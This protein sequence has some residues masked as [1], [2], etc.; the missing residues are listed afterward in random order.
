M[1]KAMKLIIFDLD[2]TILDVLPIHDMALKKAF[3]EVMGTHAAFEEVDFAGKEV[4]KIMEEL[5]RYHK[6]KKKDITEKKIKKVIERYRNAF[7]KVIPNDLNK[8]ILPGIKQLLKELKGKHLLAVMTGSAHKVPELILK[9]ARLSG[10]FDA[11]VCGTEAK[12]K[13]EMIKLIIRKTNYKDNK[14][15]V[16][17]DATR[18]IAAGKL[19]GAMTIAVNTGPHTRK[20]LKEA[21][22]DYLFDSFKDYKKVLRI[23]NS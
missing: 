3:K 21:R 10:Y 5:A 22:P 19:Y 11:A 17:G 15:I 16:I 13:E 7:K 9:K 1:K 18:D 12:S 14:I 2:Q 6:V 4:R 23:I 8:Y 20:Q